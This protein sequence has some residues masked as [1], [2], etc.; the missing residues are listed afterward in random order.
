MFALE[1]RFVL[2]PEAGL[3]FPTEEGSRTWPHGESAESRSVLLFLH[4]KFGADLCQPLIIPGEDRK[5]Q[6]RSCFPK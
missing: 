4:L 5:H 2:N 6:F 1:I 3:K